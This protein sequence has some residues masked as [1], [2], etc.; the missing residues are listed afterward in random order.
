MMDYAGVRSETFEWVG[1][2]IGPRVEPGMSGLAYL[3]GIRDGAVRSPDLGPLLNAELVEITRGRV[4]LIC[5]VPAAQLGS[6][7]EFDPGM[8]SLLIHTAVNCVAQ[9]L[10][11]LHQGWAMVASHSS[12]IR[13]TSRRL[14]SL[15]A[16]AEVAESSAER[17][18][19]KGELADEYGQVLTTVTTTLD[20]F[21][22]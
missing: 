2:V 10:M 14:G 18:V 22:L 5:S 9:T 8:A 12:Y 1:P 6:L 3:T 19:V 15:T 4:Q 13:P 20:L 11:G 17:A 21:D 16:T 7:Q